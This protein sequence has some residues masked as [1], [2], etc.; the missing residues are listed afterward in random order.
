MKPTKEPREKKGKHW[1]DGSCDPNMKLTQKNWKEF[2]AC[3]K[4]LGK[5]KP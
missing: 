3:C 2:L 1:H 5:V 4:K